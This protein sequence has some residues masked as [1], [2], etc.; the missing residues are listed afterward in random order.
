MIWMLPWLA[1]PADA[2]GGFFCEAKAPVVQA[3]ERVVFGIEPGG[4]VE[5]HVQI[6]YEGPSEEFA[7]IVPVPDKPDLFLTTSALFTQ[8]TQQSQPRFTLN[9]V[10]EGECRVPRIQAQRMSDGASYS[11]TG[12]VAAPS[13]PNDYEVEVLREETVG[14]Y[15]TVVLDAASVADLT[16]WLGANGYDI[17]SSL[18]GVL[19]PYLTS[20]S[21][22]VALKL[23]KDRSDGDLAPLALRYAGDTG[24]IPVQLTSVAATPD[25]RL[26]VYVFGAHRAVPQSYFH[27]QINDAAIDWWTRGSNYAAVITQAAD[28]AGSHAFAT[29]FAGSPERWT[30]FDVSRYDRADVVG[31]DN[32]VD[33]TVAARGALGV[34]PTELDQVV[35]NH[36]PLPDGV[37]GSQFVSCPECWGSDLPGDFDP[38]A[39]TDDLELFVV[40]PLAAAHDLVS[41]HPVV[42]RMTSSLSPIE[43]DVDP[44]F[45][46]NPDLPTE[47]SETR[48]ADLVYEC[49]SGV[50]LEE[51][52]RR[53]ELADGRV[54]DL[55]PES[56]L[57]D[58]GIS[59]FA[60]LAEHGA[61][62]AIV[63]ERT[64]EKG[65]AQVVTDHRP[66]LQQLMADHNARVRELFRGCADCSSTG[67]P[68]GLVLVGLGLLV[69]AARR[70]A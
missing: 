57:R 67:G 33:W 44:T 4:M 69:V 63:V 12:G 16:G 10:F 15:Q 20:G 26:E 1:A 68:G 65:S 5:M 54:L 25:M 61:D 34:L 31:L 46:L 17:P 8:L 7:W 41:R 14:P 19:K 29:D 42:S 22:F 28:E 3:A 18:D 70:R 43:M 66:R 38:V 47:V 48:S 59:D 11:D 50:R 6:A 32:P 60:Y 45:V 62:A 56:Y 58:E 36:V 23:A 27:V 21:K 55:P 52:L 35:E 37:T 53:L 51:A 2:C 49:N 64:G 40:E 13:S 39:A 24:A 30:S 9:R